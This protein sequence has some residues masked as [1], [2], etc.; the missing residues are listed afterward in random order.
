M[1]ALS[2]FH[3][4]RK[5]GCTAQPAP[6]FR[7]DGFSPQLLGRLLADSSQPPAPI[8]SCPAVSHRSPGTQS[9]PLVLPQ[10]SP[11]EPPASGLPQG[12]A[13]A[14]GHRPAAFSLPPVPT[15]VDDKEQPACCSL[16]ETPAQGAPCKAPP[17]SFPCSLRKSLGDRGAYMRPLPRP[18]PVWG[19]LF[20]QAG[21]EVGCQV[22]TCGHGVR[23][24]HLS[25]G[26]R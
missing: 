19:R 2:S 15:G 16:Q 11:G 14:S 23:S 26:E 22:T 6:H 21:V 18:A 20:S 17:S 1:T 24:P 25:A 7:T 13:E 12:L 9:H 8:R 10:D 3:L 4:S 5:A